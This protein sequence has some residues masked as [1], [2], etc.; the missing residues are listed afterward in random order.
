MQRNRKLNC[1]F[2]EVIV[3]FKGIPVKI[4]FCKMGKKRLVHGLLT[5]DTK[6]SFE[7]VFEIYAT[8]WTI[9]VFF[10]ECEQY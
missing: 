3:D 4:F 6:L 2:Y 5:I 10:K 8:C 1:H 7:K 9:E